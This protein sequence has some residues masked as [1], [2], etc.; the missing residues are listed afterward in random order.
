MFFLGT[1]QSVK[2]VN[3][4]GNGSRNDS[5]HI[6][7]KP[8]IVLKTY[9]LFPDIR[10]I[11]LWMLAVGHQ[12]CCLL[13]DYFDSC[14]CNGTC[15]P[16]VA[17]DTI[18]IKIITLATANLYCAKIPRHNNRIVYSETAETSDTEKADHAFCTS[19]ETD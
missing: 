17:E 10:K 11:S 8:H 16:N 7:D 6:L 15:L 2:A 4:T 12:R 19:T 3:N 13:I 9:H 14:F 5:Y 1:T 18:L